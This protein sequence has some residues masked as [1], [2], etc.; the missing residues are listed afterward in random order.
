MNW[1]VLLIGG[2]S[3]SGKTEV[4]RAVG[5]RLG[6]PWLQVD[7]LRLAFQHSQ[8]A[9]PDPQATRDL[10]FFA[11]TTHVWRQGAEALRAGLIASS[12]ALLPALEII[13]ANHIDTDAPLIIEGDN[14][15]PELIERSRLRPYVERGQLRTV[16]LRESD[17]DR[18]R[19]NIEA[20]A[21][22]TAHISP[23]EL[24]TEA[25]AKWLYSQWLMT[26]AGRL[27]QPVLE[28]RPWE[29][30]GERIILTSR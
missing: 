22:G 21:R 26:E 30:L 8:V 27:H 3:G 4:A 18:L 19:T 20:R 6:M 24:Q 16:F 13:I 10:Y 28:A 25:E 11:E 14:I 29:T 15:L 23:E 7:D 5:L 1:K 2:A 12:R 17:A 9:L